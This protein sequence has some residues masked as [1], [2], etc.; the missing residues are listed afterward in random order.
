MWLL[1]ADI[2][3]YSV[4]FGR[5]LVKRITGIDSFISDDRN[6]DI[7]FIIIMAL[8]VKDLYLK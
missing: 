4:G 3:L 2:E 6:N 5:C 1:L 8:L 7:L